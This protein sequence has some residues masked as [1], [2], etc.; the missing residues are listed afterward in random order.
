MTAPPHPCDNTPTTDFKSQFARLFVAAECR[1]QVE[2]A[3]VLEIKQSSISDA[4]RRKA[5]PA[6]W[7][8]KL[9][10]KKRINPE[11]LRSGI[12][13]KWLQVVENAGSGAEA[14][15]VINVIEYRPAKD[16]STDELL[17]ELVRRALKN[18]G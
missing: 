17:T 14:P 10:E 13:S 16:C 3:K 12:G 1:T 2:L 11:W 5:V 6:D 4:K 9:Y 7:L 18:I 8:M 15:A